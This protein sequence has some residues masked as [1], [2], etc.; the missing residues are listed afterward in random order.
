MLAGDGSVIEKYIK[1][2]MEV[3]AEKTRSTLAERDTTAAEAVRVLLR[4]NARWPGG[5][6]FVSLVA[7]EMAERLNEAGRSEWQRP[8]SLATPRDAS[9]SLPSERFLKLLDQTADAVRHRIAREASRWMSRAPMDMVEQATA[10]DT[11]PG[12]DL[13]TLAA[14]LKERLSLEEQAVLALCLEGASVGHMANTLNV[15][16]RSIYRKLQEI[17]N[18]SSLGAG[19]KGEG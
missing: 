17:K 18:Q 12:V 2:L 8:S 4:H 14:E 3:Y 6:D 16:T 7:A 15:S 10:T 19:G 11:G 5:E 1:W 9:D 13:W